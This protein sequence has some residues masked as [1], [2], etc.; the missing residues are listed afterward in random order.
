MLATSTVHNSPTK[1]GW[2]TDAL[3]EEWIEPPT[4]NSL[5]DADDKDVPYH[6]RSMQS[7]ATSNDR[8]ATAND[9]YTP[10]NDHSSTSLKRSHS[11]L[12]SSPTRQGTFL[13]RE[14]Q[15]VAPIMPLPARKGKAKNIMKDFFSPLALETMF[16]PP[17]PRLAANDNLPPHPFNT[18]LEEKH[19]ANDVASSHKA[20]EGL[21]EADMDEET[22]PVP[23]DLPEGVEEP[24]QL[25]EED[26]TFAAARPP[27]IPS[28]VPE[29]VTART[30]SNHKSLNPSVPQTDSRLRLFQF[31]YDTF[32]RDHL[33]AMVDSIA[34]HT[35]SDSNKS[36]SP[37]NILSR[38]QA[39]NSSIPVPQLDNAH[40]RATKRLR[41]TPPNNLSQDIPGVSSMPRK[42]YIGESRKLMRKIKQARS[43]SMMTV[44]SPS[45][46]H[47][48]TSLHP[49]YPTSTLTPSI[50][51]SLCSST[52]DTNSK[53]SSIASALGYRRKAADLMAQIRQDMTKGKRLFSLETIKDG[54]R[55][56][57]GYDNTPSAV[58]LTSASSIKPSTSPRKV[59]SISAARFPSS[60]GSK[61]AV[62]T[63]SEKPSIP[64]KHTKQSPRKLL[65]RLSAADEVDREIAMNKSASEVSFTASL[66]AKAS[67]KSA[68]LVTKINS[69]PQQGKPVQVFH[70]NQSLSGASSLRFLQPPAQ[71]NRV[72]SG[73][74]ATST[75]TV[76]SAL[77]PSFVKHAGP[78]QMTRIKP[79]DVPA[80]PEMVG[81]MRFDR[82][83]MR[84]VKAGSSKENAMVNEEGV[85]MH[86]EESEDPFRSF[87]SFESGSV[88]GTGKTGNL[89]ND[90][91]H[92]EEPETASV[93]GDEQLSDVH[94]SF[95]V[96]ASGHV[97]TD[98]DDS[99]DFGIEPEAAIVEV[100]TGVD[101]HV[102][103][104]E[105]ETTDSET[106]QLIQFI[107]GNADE[108][109]DDNTVT[110]LTQQATAADSSHAE[111]LAAYSTPL[112]LHRTALAPPRSV[113]KN[114]NGSVIPRTPGSIARTPNNVFGSAH[115]RSV[116]FTDGRKDGKIE[117]VGR[118]IND[119]SATGP[120]TGVSPFTASVRGCRIAAILEDLAE[121]CLEETPSKVSNTSRDLA[122]EM[123]P[124]APR[125][126][127]S[128]RPFSRSTKEKELS[129]TQA[130]QTFLT[131]CSFGISHDKLVHIITDVHPYVPYWETLERIDLGK[132]GIES[133]AR[134]K[135][136]LPQLDILNLDGNT[137]SWLTGVPKTVR[138]LSVS[139]NLLTAMT[140]FNQ[141]V[142][143][144]NLDISN[145]QLD[146]VRQLSCLRHLRELKADG[147]AIN[148][149]E[150]LGE[151]DSLTKLS[152]KGNCISHIDF[153]ELRWP[154]L[155]LLNLSR[156][157]LGSI[158]GLST[159]SSLSALN[160]DHNH[161][162]SLEAEESMPKLRTLR[163]SNNRLTQLDASCFN[164]LRTLYA[165]NNRLCDLVGAR[166]LRKLEN[167][168]LRNQGGKGLTLT[169]NDIRDVKRLY[170][171]GNPLSHPF[172]TE[173]CYN[174]I[175]LEL[176]ACRLEHLP[177]GL[178]GLIPNI[179]IL[180]LNYNFLTDASALDGLTRLRKLT[181][182]GSRLKGTKSLVR[183]LRRMPEIEMVDFRMNPCTLG[184]YL[185][186]LVQDVPGAL[187]PSEDINGGDDKHDLL[188]QN[189][190]GSRAG[191]G[192]SAA[193]HSHAQSWQELD[194]KFRCGLPDEAYV[195]RLAYR[196]LVMRACPKVRMLDGVV[197]EAGERD[198]AEM[199]L[200]GVL[201]AKTH[202]RRP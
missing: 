77:T 195:G 39:Q 132:K 136:F 179:R 170:L 45:T 27:R 174:L 83:L 64:R 17:S 14:D 201:N 63:E 172:L 171:S 35:P 23:H 85:T 42:D 74:T 48:S 142:N 183:V 180:N 173:P 57:D 43:P 177:A 98:T 127:S 166:K 129:L 66:T 122:D 135:E 18:A 79:E 158:S 71:P 9:Y 21:G 103:E 26:F 130:N 62:D 20:D 128:R 47:A 46:A 168:S 59:A 121:P 33:S 146:S 194:A 191:G 31:Q 22:R 155:E 86:S 144:E 49:I 13:I 133:V 162:V 11:P 161:L 116:S 186:I 153:G 92:G 60:S 84:W 140:S 82:V 165:D 15:P 89:Q 189:R 101:S 110:I 141:L 104:S 188:I 120:A 138:T 76:D 192:G 30:P 67:E 105:T 1:P 156:N 185:P 152:L 113:L 131:E 134:L 72:V 55:V 70:V 178:V 196:G 123:Q 12:P 190:A 160:L 87:E 25:D 7:H 54:V 19:E 118:S 193:P 91:G 2:H 111:S 90:V 182:I 58:P 143:I 119:T 24:E 154:R 97:D 164:N 150:G 149:L 53:P 29:G 139:S 52:S 147:N 99:F 69:P 6:S 40:S 117:G 176:A 115:R 187:Q 94:L 3:E 36:K 34:V 32:T 137:L 163:A 28:P 175:Y 124:L 108:D 148:S 44:L 75:E 200:Q 4:S 151:L 56:E 96:G 95:A 68:H 37:R 50:P 114:A 5:G 41:L 145:N 16:E 106:D 38:S 107:D 184:W 51:S 93:D 102:M 181:L 197:V 8:Y 159:L 112:P 80:L 78:V 73:G 169:M 202:L 88:D 61:T 126:Q 167:V 198:K 109:E 81:G 10:P 100:M 199:L 157:H 125:T 65:R